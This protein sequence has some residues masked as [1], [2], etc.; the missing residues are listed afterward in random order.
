ME[1]NKIN[2]Y[3][4]NK[5]M[6]DDLVVYK[7]AY[8][9]YEKSKN[10][11]NYPKISNY[12]GTCFMLIAKR[13]SSSPKFNNYIFKEEMVG[14]AVENCVLYIHNFDEKKYSNPFAYFTQI[15]WFAFLRRIYKEKRQ[16]YIKHKIGENNMLFDIATMGGEDIN[17][18]S[19]EDSGNI[20]IDSNIF[21]NMFVDNVKMNEIVKT[22]EESLTKKK[23]K[24]KLSKSV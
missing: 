23:E 20:D 11:K 17:D 5:K 2:N 10:E 21:N 15:V 6:F 9:A 24:R 12:L 13:L 4:D 16:L 3:I 1:K 14:D 22:F 18:N 8:R 19:L 7:E